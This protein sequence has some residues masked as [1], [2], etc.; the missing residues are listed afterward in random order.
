MCSSKPK[1]IHYLYFKVLVHFYSE[2]GMPESHQTR[3]SYKFP[4]SV[5][6][7]YAL[8]VIPSLGYIS[9]STLDLVLMLHIF[10]NTLLREW[11]VTYGNA[12]FQL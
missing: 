2:Q 3:Y 8:S 1:S 9:K 7:I 5:L 6:L 10:P 4:Q 12:H 11:F